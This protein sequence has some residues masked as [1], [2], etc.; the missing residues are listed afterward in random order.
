MEFDCRDL[1]R[2]HWTSNRLQAGSIWVNNYNITPVEL[3]F[4][5]YKLS[6]IGRECSTEAI[7]SYTQLKSIYV[8][9][10]DVECPLYNVK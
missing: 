7:Q 10:N 6:G 5:G 2:A 3:P 1:K 9:M 4:G 8:E